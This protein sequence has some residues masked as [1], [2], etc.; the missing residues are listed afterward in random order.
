MECLEGLLD[1]LANLLGGLDDSGRGLSV[2]W[3]ASWE[4]LGASWSA[5]GASWSAPGTSWKDFGS[6]VGRSWKHLEDFCRGFGGHFRAWDA[7]LKTFAEIL[8][9]LEKHYEK[10]HKN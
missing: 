5:L 4:D 8:Q 9:T 6:L 10:Y 1:S 2:I 3:E 7:S